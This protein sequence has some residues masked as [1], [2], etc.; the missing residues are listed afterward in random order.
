MKILKHFLFATANIQQMKKNQLECVINAKLRHVARNQTFEQNVLKKLQQ[1]DDKQL[2]NN[3]DDFD[4]FELSDLL[5]L[6]EFVI[7]VRLK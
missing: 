2:K 4:D 7:R 5:L 1:N 3:E 6:N